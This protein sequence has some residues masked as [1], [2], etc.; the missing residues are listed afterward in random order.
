MSIDSSTNFQTMSDTIFGIKEKLS[1][2]EFKTL[3]DQLK[4]IK[5]GSQN[6]YKLSL[7]VPDLGTETEMDNVSSLILLEISLVVDISKL[8]SFT[9]GTIMQNLKKRIRVCDLQPG[10]VSSYP[11]STFYVMRNDALLNIDTN[12]LHVYLMN[13]EKL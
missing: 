12:A 9:Q 1:D 3:M 6:F 8:H 10:L 2:Q 7:L 13:A 4:N 5:D 11:R